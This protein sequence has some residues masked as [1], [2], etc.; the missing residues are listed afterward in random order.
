MDRD[1]DAD[2]WGGPG[3]SHQNRQAPQPDP[4]VKDAEDPDHLSPRNQVSGGGGEKDVHKGH[5]AEARSTRQA[6]SEEKR[7]ERD[8]RQ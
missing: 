5:S 2:R 4:V 7:H 6:S 8:N 3:S 1:K